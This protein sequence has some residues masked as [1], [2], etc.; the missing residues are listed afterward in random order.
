VSPGPDTAS[1]Q[2]RDGLA[3]GRIVFGAGGARVGMPEVAA[4]GEALFGTPWG[5]KPWACS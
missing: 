4:A 5:R 1:R 2:V 3:D